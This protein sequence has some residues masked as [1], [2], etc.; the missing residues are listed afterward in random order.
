MVPFVNF[1]PPSPTLD[2]Y[3]LDV[4]PSS[5]KSQLPGLPGF[6]PDTL[7]PWIVQV[8]VAMTVLTL[9]CVGLRLLSR[10]LKGQGLWWDDWML[11]FSMVRS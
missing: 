9:V 3:G 7:Q 8:V 6:D 2:S 10:R 5:Q 11:L 1:P 4:M